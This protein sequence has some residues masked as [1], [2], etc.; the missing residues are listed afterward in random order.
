MSDL[1]N[2][3]DRALANREDITILE[4]G[5]GSASHF[6]FKQ[7]ARITGIDVSEKQLQRNNCL[8]KAILGDVQY[9]DFAPETFDVIIC[10]AV[11]EHL[12]RPELALNKFK[13]AVKKDGYIVL[14]TPNIFSLKGLMT[15]FTPLRFHTWYYKNLFGRK[16]AGQDD[17][18]PFKTY[19]RRTIAP[20]QIR[21][22]A[23]QNGLQTVFFEKGD[24][25]DKAYWKRKNR[26]GR[27][28]IRVYNALRALGKFVSLGKLGDSDFIIVLKK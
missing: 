1:Q 5:C 26:A 24:L 14:Q 20:D 21:K 7:R 13:R 27:F 18:G 22:F 4:A 10:W 11:L 28:F 16:K 23:A 12:P 8:F 15:K 3:L 2:F 25:G 9:Y 6:Q 19:L 17:V